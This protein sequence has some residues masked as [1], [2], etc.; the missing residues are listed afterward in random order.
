M[1]QSSKRARPD[2]CW[3]ER[4]KMWR[5]RVTLSDGRSHDIYG[6]TQKEVCYANTIRKKPRVNGSNRFWRFYALCST[7]DDDVKIKYRNFKEHGKNGLV[8]IIDDRFEIY[9]LSW[10]DVFQAFEAR[11]STMLEKLKLDQSLALSAVP[12][13]ENESP[14]RKTVDELSKRLVEFRV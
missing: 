5:K 6:K 7:V 13:G 3:I 10:D 8:D 1:A 4:R 11:H 2:M 9:A 14:L 12:T